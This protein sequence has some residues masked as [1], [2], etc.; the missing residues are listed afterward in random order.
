MIELLSGLENQMEVHTLT[1]DRRVLNEKV[2]WGESA[3]ITKN[4][5]M[6]RRPIPSSIVLLLLPMFF[7][8]Y[9]IELV[10]IRPDMLLFSDDIIGLPRLLIHKPRTIIVYAH[11]PL[12]IKLKTML[13]IGRRLRGF[14]IS[15]A[16]F[17]SG[18]VA[19]RVLLGGTAKFANVIICNSTYTKRFVD[20]FWG[21]VDSVVVP[22]PVDI[23]R[24]PPGGKSRKAVMLG[25]LQRFKQQEMGIR[26]LALCKNPVDLIIVGFVYDNEPDYWLY[27]KDLA[28]RLGME[29]RV[30]VIPNASYSVVK[31][32]LA[33][34]SIIIHASTGEAFGI[35]VVEAMAAGCV[36]VVTPV[37]GL[38][39]FVLAEG[40]YGF[41][42][43]NENELAQRL[44]AL[45]DN[46]ILMEECK[47]KAITRAR[48]FSREVFAQRIRDIFGQELKRICNA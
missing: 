18:K 29:D 5:W 47:A 21:R 23:E 6:I 7:I 15:R 19:F 35:A 48:E 11:F 13:H 36:P 14:G 46:P 39:D 1:L 30:K 22:P 41:A 28:K 9:N 26:A 25:A 20:E 10:R 32:V 4:H 31:E 3:V 2:V 40:K 43:T 38:W 33:T 45:F 8:W 16:I 44:D 17:L 12:D 34:S 24:Y 37:E 42:F 27:L